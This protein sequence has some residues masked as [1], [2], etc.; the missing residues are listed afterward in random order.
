[1]AK[2]FT[3]KQVS[4]LESKE[5]AAIIIDNV[6]Y[7]VSGFLEDHPGGPEVLLN[8][9]GQDASRCFHEVGHS[10]DARAWRERFRIGEIAAED[11]WEVLKPPPA[12]DVATTKLTWS[13]ALDVLAPPLLFAA[14]AVL[15]YIYFF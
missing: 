14:V 2:I 12:F 1:M 9:A 6:V 13:G 15:G 10:E 4:E 11:C 5:N 8:N 3:R 7:D